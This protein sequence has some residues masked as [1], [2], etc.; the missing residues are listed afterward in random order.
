MKKFV[1]LYGP[2]DNFSTFEYESYNSTVKNLL[3]SNV[4]TL[5]QVTKNCGNLQCTET[6]YPEP[7]SEHS[8]QNPLKSL[9]NPW[10]CL[11]F[12]IP[13]DFLINVWNSFEIFDLL[14]LAKTSICSNKVVQNK[15]RLAGRAN[16]E[17]SAP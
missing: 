6:W 14:Y 2:R 3:K 12:E 11:N 16:L 7:I 4:M 15:L 9:E 5:T 10:N 8:N 13:L 1:D 17:F